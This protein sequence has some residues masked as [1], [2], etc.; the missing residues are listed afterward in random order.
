MRH[1]LQLL[2]V[3][4]IITCADIYYSGKDKSGIVPLS[5]AL[6]GLHALAGWFPM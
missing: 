1:E 6:F 5:I 3:I 4:L 2:A